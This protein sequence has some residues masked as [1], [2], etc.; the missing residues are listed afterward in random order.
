MIASDIISLSILG[1]HKT[2]IV[3]NSREQAIALLDKKSAN[4]SDRPVLY[5]LGVLMGWDLITGF[6]PYNE[7]WRLLRKEMHRF[8]G[9]PSAVARYHPEIEREA[10]RL[11]GA[12]IK[13]PATWP[14]QVR[15]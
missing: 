8:M 6:T 9:T 3:L 11:V 15:R 1:P 10:K 5:M 14:Y 4:Y 12:I 7:R 2:I 13:D